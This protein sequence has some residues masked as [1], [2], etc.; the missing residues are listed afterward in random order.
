MQTML[1]TFSTKLDIVK[2][3]ISYIKHFTSVNAAQDRTLQRQQQSALKIAM[4]FFSQKKYQV[5][6]L[7]MD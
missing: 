1:F 4:H 3:S 7:Y 2:Q 6:N 5:Y